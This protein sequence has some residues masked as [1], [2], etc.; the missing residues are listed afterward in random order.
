MRS[1]HFSK[2][3]LIAILFSGMALCADDKSNKYGRLCS[4]VTDSSEQVFAAGNGNSARAFRSAPTVDQALRDILDY[5]GLDPGNGTP[6][7]FVAVAS[8]DPA[9]AGNAVALVCPDRQ[10]YVF[11]DPKFLGQLGSVNGKDWPKYFVLAHEVGHHLL[12]HSMDGRGDV[13]ALELAADSYAGFLLTRMGAS[14]DELL[15]GV[16]QIV[17]T[18]ETADHPGRC[19]RRV[20]VIEA[21]NRGARQIGRPAAT[22]VNSCDASITGE[23]E[24]HVQQPAEQT[25]IET[26]KTEIEKE[27][28]NPFNA[29]MDR[30]VQACMYDCVN[31]YRF[32]ESDCRK[33]HCSAGT[34]PAWTRRCLASTH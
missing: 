1:L 34:N 3:T 7:N 21:Y 23:V 17:S 32:K 28:P 20:A 22:I 10:R 8:T 29:C 6:P 2:S 16:D 30:K 24:T 19:S 4:V 26:S 11:Y 14:I 9:I 15:R 18:S 13:K 12:N 5:A 25:P 31:H 33:K 27:S